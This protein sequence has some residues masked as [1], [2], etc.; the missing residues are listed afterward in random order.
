MCRAPDN[1]TGNR[2]GTLKVVR[3]TAGRSHGSAIWECRCDCGARVYRTRA[4]LERT[5]A[6]TSGHQCPLLRAHNRARG[7]A[8]RA[9][10][11]AAYRRLGSLRRAAAEV[12]VTRERVRQVVHEARRTAAYQ[13]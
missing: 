13:C 11:L 9:S 8:R 7:A 4:N 3:V 2:Y 5:G 6:H 12:G 10:I 1:I